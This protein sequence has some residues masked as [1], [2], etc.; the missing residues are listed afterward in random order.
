MLMTVLA[1]IVTHLV[2]LFTIVMKY[3]SVIEVMY[4][5]EGELVMYVTS[6][7]FVRWSNYYSMT[8]SNGQ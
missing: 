2:L 3:M 4:P 7:P 6:C 8:T 1:I 5:K